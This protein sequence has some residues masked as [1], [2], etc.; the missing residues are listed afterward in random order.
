MLALSQKIHSILDCITI[1]KSVCINPFTSS[2]F[3]QERTA[4]EHQRRNEI[5][6]LLVGHFRQ[7]NLLKF[8]KLQSRNER[9]A[10]KIRGRMFVNLFERRFEIT[11]SILFSYIHSQIIHTERTNE[12]EWCKSFMKQMKEIRGNILLR[13]LLLLTP[14][15]KLMKNYFDHASKQRKSCWFTKGHV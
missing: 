2:S 11:F 4:E 6:T 13:Y 3:I 15:G 10:E 1:S 5:S 9:F 7:L 8:Q 14:S 12:E